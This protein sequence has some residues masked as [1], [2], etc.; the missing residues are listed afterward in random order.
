MKWIQAAFF[1]LAVPTV[2][3]AAGPDDLLAKACASGLPWQLTPLPPPFT[4]TEVAIKL[5]G[6][7]GQMVSI[8]NCTANVAGKNTGVWVR[9][10]MSNDTLTVMAK[11]GMIK[12]ATGKQAPEPGPGTW[13]Y[14]LPGRS[15]MS[16]GSITIILAPV[17]DSMATWGSFESSH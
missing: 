10:S 7:A 1:A 8:C 3:A 15:C 5:N 6:T 12:Q 17:D 14:Y 2:A 11:Q 16:A 13:P 9:S 4:T